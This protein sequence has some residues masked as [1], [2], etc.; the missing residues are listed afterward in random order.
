MHVVSEESE[1]QRNFEEDERFFDRPIFHREFNAARQ[2]A[3]GAADAGA[4]FAVAVLLT[5]VWVRPASSGPAMQSGCTTSGPASG[6]FTVTLCFVDP[7]DWGELVGAEIITISAQPSGSAPGIRRMVFHL[8]GEYL[9]TDFAS[10]YTFILPTDRFV[11]GS[12][13]FEVEAL[14]R[15]GFT[16]DRTAI[17]VVFNNGVTEP[18]TSNRTFIPRTGTTPPP[19]RPFVVAAVGDGAGGRPE[20]GDVT[21]LIAS[22]SPNIILYLG[23]VYEKGTLTEFYNWYGTPDRFYGRFRSITNPSIGNHEYEGG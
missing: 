23:D 7:E 16:T 1:N 12:Y 6:E 13:L 17:N 18:P 19:G 3:R 11:D 14:M 9:L 8:A 4:V 10:P 22:W 20:A 5:V 15:D 21:D 2:H